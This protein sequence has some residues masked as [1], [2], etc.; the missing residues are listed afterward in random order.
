MKQIQPSQNRHQWPC[1]AVQSIET[2]KRDLVIRI[3]DWSRQ[4]INTGEP[5]YDVEVYVGG[6]YDW[7][8]SETCTVRQHGSKQAAKA[9]AVAFAQAFYGFRY[10]AWPVLIM[11]VRRNAGGK[12][13]Q[14][15]E[16]F[17]IRGNNR[18][19]FG[20]ATTDKLAFAFPTA[21]VTPPA[22]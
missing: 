5:A 16:A 13:R 3:A 1:K 6:V 10:F 7:N 21:H 18:V 14:L 9:A 20:T 12:I 15:S 19:I 8:A 11:Q 2:R 17:K 4:S 22:E